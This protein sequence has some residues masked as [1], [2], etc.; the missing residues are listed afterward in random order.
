MEDKERYT[1]E[2][3]SVYEEMRTKK[4][5]TEEKNTMDSE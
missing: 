2:K 4:T 1:E 3:N 5:K